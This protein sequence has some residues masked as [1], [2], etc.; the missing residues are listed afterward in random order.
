[1]IFYKRFCSTPS[2]STDKESGYQLPAFFVPYCRGMVLNA[3]TRQGR[4]FPVLIP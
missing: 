4:P 3:V 1:M 2:S